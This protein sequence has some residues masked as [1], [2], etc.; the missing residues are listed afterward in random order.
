MCNPRFPALIATLACLCSAGR[1]AAVEDTWQYTTTDPGEGWQ[2]Q[3]VNPDHEACRQ[4]HHRARPGGAEA[5]TGQELGRVPTS[6]RADPALEELGERLDVL[7]RPVEVLGLAL[8]D[9]PPDQGGRPGRRIGVLS[10]A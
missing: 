7:I 1:S 4:T 3:G 5:L 10:T 2:Q 9:D 8:S 6:I